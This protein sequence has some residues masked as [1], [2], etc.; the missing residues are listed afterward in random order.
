MVEAPC[1]E[2]RCPLASTALSARPMR[3]DQVLGRRAPRAAG[4][5][6]QLRRAEGFH[7][8]VDQHAGQQRHADLAVA[9]VSPSAIDSGTPSTRIPAA[10][11]APVPP[12][13][14]RATS[15]SAARPSRCARRVAWR[16]APRYPQARRRTRCRAASPPAGRKPSSSGP[17][18]RRL[19]HQLQRGTR[20]TGPPPPNAVSVA[21]TPRRQPKPGCHQRPYEEARHDREPPATLARG[22]P[23]TIP[24]LPARN[25]ASPRPLSPLTCGTRWRTERCDGVRATR[26]TM[27]RMRSS[28]PFGPG[29]LPL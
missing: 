9:T 15:S 20:P 3:H 23:A 26:V 25:I 10:M 7:D 4:G 8:I 27:V 2:N 6:D 5:D 16:A 29:R 18:V 14:V 17:P 1:R 21:A 13:C 22:L 28:M 24:H 11:G 12:R 19:E